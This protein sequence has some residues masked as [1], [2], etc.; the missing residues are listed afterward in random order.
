M[1]R[2]TTSTLGPFSVAQG[3]NYQAQTIEAYNAGTGTLNLTA[4]VAQTA[5]SWLAANVGTARTCTTTRAASS[6]IPINFTFNTSSLAAGTYTGIVTINDPNAVDAPQTV[7]VTVN[8]GGGIPSSLNVYVA[9]G[10][11]VDTVIPTNN[12]VT[13][14]ART[15]DGNQWL[16]LELSGAGSFSFS[17]PY[18]VQVKPQAA[19]GPGTYTGT[20]TISGSAFAPDNKAIAVTMNVTTGAIAQQPAPVNLTLAQGTVAADYFGTEATVTNSGQATLTVSGAPAVATNGGNW[21]TATVLTPPSIPPGSVGAYLNFDTTG[22]SPGTYTGTVKFSTNAAAVCGT[23]GCTAGGTVTVPVNLTVEAAGA[24]VITYQGVLDNATFVPGATVAQGDVMAVK[25]DRLSLSAIALG[26][27]PPLPTTLADTSVLVNG[28]PA[29]LYYTSYGQI[30]FQMPVNTPTGTATVQV[31]RTDGSV[32]NSV[33]VNVAAAAPKLLLIYNSQY[34][35][36]VNQDGSLPLPASYSLTGGFAAH[37]AKAGDT[38]V[39]Y[40][41][42]LGATSPAVATGQPAPSTAPYAPLVS[43][44]T[45]N[46]GGSPFSPTATPSYAGLTPTYAGLYQVNVQIPPG[47]R[48]GTVYVYLATASGT[49]NSVA[50]E[51]Q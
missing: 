23:T 11:T 17:N 24:P 29:P 20:L 44:P 41:I 40:A 13:G 26:P 37:P 34:A 50:I 32:S 19:N 22:L 8:V 42:G 43:T 36:A 14:T 49:S 6:C 38:L 51:V 33:S 27:A 31:K 16:A 25:G 7:T 46:F 28:T 39:F 15:N 47:V 9:P 35:A 21:M 10:A 45:V 12:S 18:V 3:S 30:A 1:L 2:L 4:T 5:T 48:P